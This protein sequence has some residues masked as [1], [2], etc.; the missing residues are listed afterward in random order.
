[1]INIGYFRNFVPFSLI[2]ESIQQPCDCGGCKYGEYD[3]VVLEQPALCFSALF[4]IFAGVLLWQVMINT[5]LISPLFVKQLAVMGSKKSGKTFLTVYLIERFSRDG[6]RVAGVKHIHH[7]FSIDTEGKDTWR[8]ARSGAELVA[9]VSPNETAV[10]FYNKEKWGTKIERL[11]KIL[12]SEEVEVVIYEGFYHLLGKSR[13]VYKIFAV[14]DLS[15]IEMFKGL[16]K[17]VVAVFRRENISLQ[18]ID[19][20]VFGPD[21]SEG[22]YRYV[23]REIGLN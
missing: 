19:V 3:Q 20:P 16:E 14:K 13:E 1:M 7:E 15:E 5:G 21:L 23:K 10:L 8:M 18:D 22:F 11:V 2:V 17:P 4:L 9:S 6:Y 12:E